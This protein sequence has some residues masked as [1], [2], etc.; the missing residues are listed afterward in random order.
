MNKHDFSEILLTF[1][2]ILPS[3]IW[4]KN[5]T[6][7]ETLIATILTQNTSDKNAMQ[8]FKKLKTKMNLASSVEM[9]LFLDLY[10][11]IPTEF[12]LISLKA[13]NLF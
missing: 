8:A 9:G 7:F 4:T 3:S 11:E 12:I 5:F 13:L 1:E 6:P 10:Q 2:K